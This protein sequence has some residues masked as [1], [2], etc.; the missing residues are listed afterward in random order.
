ME[1]EHCIHFISNWRPRCRRFLPDTYSC[2][3]YARSKFDDEGIREKIRAGLEGED[4][5]KGKFLER[6]TYQRGEYDKPEGYKELHRI[7]TEREAKAD[8]PVARMFYLAVPPTTYTSIMTQIKAECSKFDTKVPEESWLRVV[9]EKPFGRDL[10]SSE[11]L[12]AHIGGL[13]SEEQV[14]RIDHF[15][16]KELVQVRSAGTSISTALSSQTD[17]SDRLASRS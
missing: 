17:F 9:I 7:M 3:G 6:L 8:G 1:A 4:A 2:I 5:T 13:F 10:Q 16:G 14:Y 12:S 15:L 11:E